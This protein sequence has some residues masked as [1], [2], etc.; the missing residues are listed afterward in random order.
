MQYHGGPSLDPVNDMRLWRSVIEQHDSYD[1]LVLW[2][3]HDLFDQ[4]ALMRHQP[5]VRWGAFA[6]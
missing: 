3:E 6:A 2:F 4:L 1:E 5:L